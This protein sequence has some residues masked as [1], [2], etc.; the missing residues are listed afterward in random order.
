[1]HPYGACFYDFAEKL[2]TGLIEFY[3]HNNIKQ[4]IVGGLATEYCVLTTVKQLIKAG[5]KIILNLDGCKG[6][7]P[8]TTENAL[9]EMY[10]LN[11][12]LYNADKLDNL[13]RQI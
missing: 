7:A 5:F 11:V 1:M 8:D 9:K 2:S 13:V 12:D 6:I 10:K 3:K 4:V